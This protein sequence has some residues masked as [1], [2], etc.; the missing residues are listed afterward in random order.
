MKV[1]DNAGGLS[2]VADPDAARLSDGG[3]LLTWTHDHPRI[4]RHVFGQRFT[5][6]AVR[7]GDSFVIST[8]MGSARPSAAPLPDKGFVVVYRL[9][10]QGIVD[11]I[12][13]QRYNASG[14]RVG[15]EFTVL[16]SFVINDYRPAV[17][18]QK[19]GVL[20]AI[21]SAPEANPKNGYGV[22]GQRFTP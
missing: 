16:M 11:G 20:V 8:I 6:N 14:G 19:D 5:A 13:G 4:G 10:E 9:N 21:W 17:A 18:A 3:F 12:Y 15:S 1:A 2:G 7:K 22:F